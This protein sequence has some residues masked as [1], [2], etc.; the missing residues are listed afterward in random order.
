MADPSSH[1]TVEHSLAQI[2]RIEAFVVNS[3][4]VP[5]TAKVII[6]EVDFF[7]LLDQLRQYLPA[8]IQQAQQII[9]NQ[10]N[11]LQEARNTAQKIVD[12]T[13]A[14]TQQYLQEHELVKQ[15]EK[16]AEETRR[17]V[18]EE[19]KK[20]RYEA[21]KYSEEVL[22]D[23]EQ[24]VQRALGMVKSGRQNLARNM[25]ETAQKMGI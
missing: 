22:A 13:K 25:E 9:Q 19:I 3:L 14:K 24:K 23:L 7:M 1:Q 10:A 6:D 11:I 21:D 17:N 15:A 2:D 5:L 4:H 18:A 12:A 8:E 20:Q 16:V